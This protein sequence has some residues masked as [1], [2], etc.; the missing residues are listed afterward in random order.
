MK[1]E[2]SISYS[3][4]FIAMVKVDN[5]QTNQQTDRTK[6]IFPSYANHLTLGHESV[7]YTTLSTDFLLES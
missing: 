6:R 5:L 3:S 7:K 4:K 1:Y 2:V